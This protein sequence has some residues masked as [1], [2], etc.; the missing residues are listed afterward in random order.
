[1]VNKDDAIQ[2]YWNLA[3]QMGYE[4]TEVSDLINKYH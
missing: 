3:K 4:T 1:M 2:M